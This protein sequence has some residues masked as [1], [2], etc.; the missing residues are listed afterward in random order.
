MG[1][2]SKYADHCEP[3]SHWVRLSIMKVRVD[4]HSFVSYEY[5]LDSALVKPTR[6]M[7]Q[8]AELDPQN[9]VKVYFDCKIFDATYWIAS[10][11]R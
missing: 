5:Q 2:T 10:I 9:K 8:T 6:Q 11:N 3:N 4:T 7:A 1:G